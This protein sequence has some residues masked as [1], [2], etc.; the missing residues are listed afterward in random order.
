[1]LREGLPEKLRPCRSVLIHVSWAPMYTRVEV[2][3]WFESYRYSRQIQRQ[4][5][6]FSLPQ[7][8][9][10]EGYGWDARMEVVMTIDRQQRLKDVTRM[11]HWMPVWYSLYEDTFCMDN[12]PQ[13]DRLS[14]IASSFE[15][16]SRRYLSQYSSFWR[17]RRSPVLSVLASRTFLVRALCVRARC[18]CVCSLLGKK[19]W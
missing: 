3:E 6:R 11:I 7:Y 17:P 8:G 12:W 1:M 9:Y 2:R 5:S 19:Y 15:Q 14:C 13:Y 10:Q 18:P 4:D 16:K